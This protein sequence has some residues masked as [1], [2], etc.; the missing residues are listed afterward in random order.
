[1]VEHVTLSE[2]VAG[3]NVPQRRARVLAA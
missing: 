2:H 3:E 1:M